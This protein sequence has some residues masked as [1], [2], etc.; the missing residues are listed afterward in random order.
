MLLGQPV[1]R[2]CLDQRGHH[3]V[4]FQDA[5]AVAKPAQHPRGPEDTS[6]DSGL[7]RS[8]PPSRAGSLRRRQ[9]TSVQLPNRSVRRGAPPPEN[10]T[11][12][13]DRHPGSP[14]RRARRAAAL[15][16]LHRP[17]QL[18]RTTPPRRPRYPPPCLRGQR[19]ESA[20]RA[21]GC[22]ARPG[23]LPRDAVRSR[24]RPHPPPPACAAGRTGGA[25]RPPDTTSGPRSART[26]PGPPRPPRPGRPRRARQARCTR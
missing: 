20:T 8:C 13:P 22:G 21:P 11:A 23:G 10:W 15:P 24:R 2:V 16:G 17:P 26:S 6:G 14:G 25:W 1:Q 7:R 12:A 18:H 4:G 5:H 9:V 19:R 3:P